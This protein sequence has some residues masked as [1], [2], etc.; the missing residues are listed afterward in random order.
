MEMEWT[1][2]QNGML[3]LLKDL[4]HNENNDS[5]K[6]SIAHIESTRT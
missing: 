6:R 1:E 4:F 2:L 3:Q 5:T